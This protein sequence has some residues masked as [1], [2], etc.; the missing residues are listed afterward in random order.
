M[1]CISIRR[2][3]NNITDDKL[4][5]IGEYYTARY[6]KPWQKKNSNITKGFYNWFIQQNTNAITEAIPL[7]EFEILRDWGVGF[8]IKRKKPL[9]KE[10]ID[11]R[12]GE[13]KC[14]M[15][16]EDEQHDYEHKFSKN[17]K[18]YDEM[19]SKSE[20]LIRATASQEEL[21]NWK[22]VESLICKEANRPDPSPSQEILRARLEYC[23]DGDTS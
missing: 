8:F 20:S 6:N 9:T 2:W 11:E 14:E 3:V 17:A 7:N 18:A 10:E 1:N 5:H 15:N 13:I 22:F 16:D 12:I 21:K 4:H 19:V 23:V